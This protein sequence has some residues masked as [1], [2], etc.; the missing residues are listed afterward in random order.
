MIKEIRITKSNAW[1]LIIVFILALL[2][3]SCKDVGVQPIDNTFDLTVDD[4]SCTEVWLRIKLG[5]GNTNREVTLKRDT[6]VLFTRRINDLETIVMDTNLTPNHTYNYT[7]SLLNGPMVQAQATTMDI[8]SHNFTWQTYT[9][10]GASSSVLEDIAI[11]NDT[12]AYA[13]GEIYIND[14]TGKVDRQPYNLAIWNGKVWNIQKIPYYYQGQSLYGPIHSLWA[15]N[16]NDIWFGIG[17]MIHWDGQT[18]NAVELPSTAWGPHRINKIWGLSSQNFYIVGVGGSI[19]HYNGTTWTKIESG[20]SEDIQD[21]FGYKNAITGQSTVLCISSTIGYGGTE[22]ILSLTN[23]SETKIST[24]GLPWSI[25][26]IWFE[27]HSYY[28]VGDGMFHKRMLQ[29]AAWQYFDQGLTPNYL[30]AI[31]GNASNDIVA[32]GAYGTV[33]HYNGSTWYNYTRQIN[34]SSSDLHAVSMQRNQI[35]A[36]GMLGGVQA[37]ILM[38]TR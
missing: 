29:D 35:I 28:I 2:S 19:A 25:R 26:G 5:L 11:I 23:T 13:V 3:F 18:F 4:A 32:V 9:F 31:R 34:L 20:V 16:A 22:N 27:D 8:T 37:V 33:L 36:V 6:V 21:I 10:G 15:F 38:G 17:N 24:N 1:I 30:N 14:S 12:L 7:A